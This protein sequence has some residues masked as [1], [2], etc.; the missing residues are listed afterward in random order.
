MSV[1]SLSTICIF[2]IK[3]TPKLEPAQSTN[4]QRKSIK[5]ILFLL[6]LKLVCESQT[7]GALEQYAS[8]RPSFDPF[9]W[10]CTCK[11]RLLLW[12]PLYMP[13]VEKMSSIFPACNCHRHSFDCLYDNEVAQRHGSLD[14]RGDYRG[15]GVC[16]NCQVGHALTLGTL[17]FC[18]FLFSTTVLF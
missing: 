9:P 4:R 7:A 12:R 10:P 5:H 6:L 8:Q 11:L 13:W 14:I 3:L 2:T 17:L 1:Q 15:G 18:L 16:L